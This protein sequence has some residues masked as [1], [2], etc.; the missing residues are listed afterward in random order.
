MKNTIIQRVLVVGIVALGILMNWNSTGFAQVSLTQTKPI[1]ELPQDVV[2]LSTG[3]TQIPKGAYEVAKE[4]GPVAGAILGPVKGTATFVKWT[5]EE[6]W[7]ALK[8]E[9]DQKPQSLEERGL[10]FRYEF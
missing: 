10:A 3:W 4:H 5:A 6:L 1:G 9:T 8:T 7:N 2:S